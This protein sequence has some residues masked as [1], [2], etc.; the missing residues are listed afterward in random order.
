[1]KSLRSIFSIFFAFLALFS[2]SS[3]VVGIH[4]CLGEVSNIALFSRAEGCAMERM[5]PSCRQGAKACCQDDVVVHEGQGFENSA[6][7]VVAPTPPDIEPSQPSVLLSDLFNTRAAPE[8]RNY[9]PP[10]QTCDRT[11]ALQ[12]FLI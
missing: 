8:S 12:T 4:Y 11:V 6:A 9:I 5:Q 10:L 3:F 7:Q 1:M 2:T